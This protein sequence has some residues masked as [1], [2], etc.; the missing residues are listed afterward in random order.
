[1]GLVADFATF[2]HPGARRAGGCAGGR[3]A[4]RADGGDGGLRGRRHRG[5]PHARLRRAAAVSANTTC[6]REFSSHP[7]LPPSPL[8][9]SSR[10]AERRRYRLYASAMLLFVPLA[11]L[12]FAPGRFYSSPGPLSCEVPRG[13]VARM[14]ALPKVMVDIANTGVNSRCITASIVVDTGVAEV[15]A[16]LTDY[17][18]LATHVPNLVVS[19]RRPAPGGVIRI[20][21]E[22]AQSIVGFDFRAALEMDMEEYIDEARRTTRQIKF[23]LVDSAMFATFDGEWRVQ[24]YSRQRMRND[25]TRY[26]YKSKLTYIV[27]IT[28]KGLVPIPAIEWR[29]KEDVPSN[30]IG[31]KVAAEAALARA[32]VK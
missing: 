2:D 24:P 13:H 11:P 28:P 27:N 18:N 20:Y 31:V 8:T 21:Q 25:P 4:C 32:A 15:W 1:M 5:L 9:Q 16:I 14:A 3:H 10:S 6:S 17:D 12:S 30:L 22:G 29:I 7:Y 19:E 23:T 26:S